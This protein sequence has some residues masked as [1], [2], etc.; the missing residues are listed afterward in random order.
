MGLLAA[1]KLAA[2]GAQL[3]VFDRCPSDATHRTIEA[4]RR[5]DQPPVSFYQLDVADRSQVL[6]V[7]ARAAAECGAP[8]IVINM[9]GIGGVAEFVDMPFESFDR[10]MQIN[11]YGSRNV[12]EAVVPLMLGSNRAAKGQIVLVGSMGGIVP[13]YGYTAYGT[14]K[15]AVVG[16]AQ[17]L[18]YELKPRGLDVLCFCPGEVLTPGLVAERQATHPAAAAMKRLGG[19]MPIDHAVDALLS[20]ICRRQFMIMPGWK[21]WLTHWAF[22]LTPLKLWNAISDSIVSD[23]LRRMKPL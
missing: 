1:Q 11:V 4:A 6:Q 21:V 16:F 3:V 18:R 23:A 12:C 15:F 20:G 19:T 17:C 2:R 22:R 9:A 7:I 13:V 8:N 10:M 5:T 14:S